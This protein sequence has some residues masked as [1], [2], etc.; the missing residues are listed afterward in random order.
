MYD[1]QDEI[2]KDFNQW[3]KDNNLFDIQ[4]QALLNAYAYE[5]GWA[6]SSDSGMEIVDELDN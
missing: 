2:E 1:L 5:K 3:V 4:K 6:Q